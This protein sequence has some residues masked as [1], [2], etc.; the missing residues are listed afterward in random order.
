MTGE[1]AATDLSALHIDQV[2]LAICTTC[3]KDGAVRAKGHGYEAGRKG[4]QAYAHATL[5]GQVPQANR[6]I[7]PIAPKRAGREEGG[8]LAIG[9]GSCTED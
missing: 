8:S 4:D 5:G 9:L 3:G 6:P 2:D 1:R 7:R